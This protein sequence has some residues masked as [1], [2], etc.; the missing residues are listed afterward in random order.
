MKKVFFLFMIIVVTS[1]VNNT[2]A[3]SCTPDH[4]GY[5]VVPDSGIIIPSSL[6]NA[7]VGVLYEQAITLGVLDSA[8]GYPVNWI[9]YTSLTN[10]LTTNSWTI[11]NSTGGSTFPQW[12]KLTWQC[13]ALKGTPTTA[14]IDSIRIF[15]NANVSIMGFPYTQSN[16]KAFVI[17][18]I[19]NS[20]TGIHENTNTKF[21]QCFPNPATDKIYVESSQ[22]ASLEI[23]NIQGQTIL[24]Q[25]IQPGK[26]NIDISKFAKGVYI[27]KSS[28][29][30]NTEVIRF[31]KE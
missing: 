6:P 5:T 30:E 29:N 10:Y 13:V 3:Q 15:I 24:Q 7:Q 18:I 26:T 25:Q 17:P 1:I 12:N 28:N 31:V 19:V 23:L 21:I 16:V 27:L 22:S 4:P 20:A 9:Q 8:M 11:V 2:N 14:G